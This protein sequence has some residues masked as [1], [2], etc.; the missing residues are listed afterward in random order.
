MRTKALIGKCVSLKR[1][2]ASETGSKE[3]VIPGF[4]LRE[5]VKFLYFF[6]IAV[7]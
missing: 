1:K 2:P 3:R 7:E 6:Q 5:V 4:D